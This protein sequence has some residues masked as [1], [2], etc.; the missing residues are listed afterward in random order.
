MF[1]IKPYL[2]L[3]LLNNNYE[4]SAADMSYD[5]LFC[6]AT[7]IYHEARS[8]SLSGQIAVGSVVLNRVKNKGFPN[9]ICEV[10]LQA[11]K[12]KIGNPIINMCHFSWYCD[13]LSD[14]I[15][16]IVIFKDIAELSMQIIFGDFPDNTGGALHYY[17]PN[18]AN[19]YWKDAYNYIITIDSHDYYDG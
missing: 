1:D 14:K 17:N 5:D 13:G 6:M 15:A 8:E 2:L 18:L 7:N 19:P 16:N 3:L 9:T 4:I 12:D 10:V 11:K